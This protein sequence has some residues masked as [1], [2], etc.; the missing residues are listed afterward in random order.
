[1]AKDSKHVN[2]DVRKGGD[3]AT[4]VTRSE[5]SRTKSGSKTRETLTTDH[6]RIKGGR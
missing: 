5:V 2:W 4:H 1:M 3:G 6:V